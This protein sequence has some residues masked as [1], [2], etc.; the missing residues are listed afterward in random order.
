MSRLIILLILFFLLISIQLGQAFYKEGHSTPAI[1]DPCKLL[2]D[3]Y[4]DPRQL[5]KRCLQEL[6]A[7]QQLCPDIDNPDLDIDSLHALCTNAWHR[8]HGD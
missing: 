6:K 5:T 2:E 7:I 3:P 8:I 1:Q 4:V